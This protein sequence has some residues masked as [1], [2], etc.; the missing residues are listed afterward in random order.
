MKDKDWKKDS[1][2]GVFCEKRFVGMYKII[3]DGEIF[4]KAEFVMQD[5]KGGKK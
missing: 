4:A 2:V 5:L 1:V 3:N